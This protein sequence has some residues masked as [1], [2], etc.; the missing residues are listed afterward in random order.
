MDQDARDRDG[1]GDARL[2]ALEARLK[3]ALED[4]PGGRADQGAERR[5]RARSEGI[6]WRISTEL[7]ASFLVCGFVGWWVD[8]WSGTRPFALVAGLVLGGA[9][10]IRNVFRVSRSMTRDAEGKE[11]E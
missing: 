5:E 9:V 11:D 7:V 6:A 8:E 10:G 3:A 2:D 4:G 1:A